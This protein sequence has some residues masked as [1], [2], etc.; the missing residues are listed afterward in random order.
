MGRTPARLRASPMANSM[1]CLLN[2][3]RKLKADRNVSLKWPLNFI[4]ITGEG[5]KEQLEYFADDLKNVTNSAEV[6]FSQKAAAAGQ[7]LSAKT[8]DGKFEVVAEFSLEAS[9][10]E[11]A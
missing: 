4:S 1:R 8:E 9:N 5:A 2:I 10:V 3:V 11:V 6:V 7:G